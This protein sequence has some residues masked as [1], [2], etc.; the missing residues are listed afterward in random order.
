[1][2]YIHKYVYKGSDRTIAVV[3]STDDE[4]TCYVQGRYIGPTEAI[5]RLFEFPTHQEWPPV[6]HLPV[7]LPGQHTIYFAD[8]LTV[9]QVATKA[10]RTRSKLMAF[11]LYNK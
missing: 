2:K 1:M 11:F 10:E 7:H 6:E 4:I 8:N 3:R 5:W 9:S